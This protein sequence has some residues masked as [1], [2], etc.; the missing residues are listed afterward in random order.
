MKKA[1]VGFLATILIFFVYLGITKTVLN[2]HEEV[3]QEILLKEED[4]TVYAYKIIDNERIYESDKRWLQ[5]N[6][7]NKY[8]ITVKNETCEDL[9][10]TIKCKDSRKKVLKKEVTVKPYGVKNYVFIN[11]VAG[12]HTISFMTSSG[13]ISG[14]VTVELE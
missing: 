8:K 6:G 10:V 7:S 13:V 2:V 3:E 11:A 9:K 14:I 4:S 5:P 12:E 1:L